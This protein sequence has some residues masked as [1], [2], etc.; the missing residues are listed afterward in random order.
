[1]ELHQ[2]LKAVADLKISG[3]QL[4]CQFGPAAYDL[5]VAAVSHEPLNEIVVNAQDDHHVGVGTAGLMDLVGIDHDEFA[6]NQ[7]VLASLQIN[8][9]RGYCSSE[10]RYCQAYLSLSV[11]CTKFTI[12]DGEAQGLS[13][14]GLLHK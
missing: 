13:G 3:N 8:G 10:D 2:F 12:S 14:G 6:G 7:L 4:I 9:R 1:M 5:E 11:I